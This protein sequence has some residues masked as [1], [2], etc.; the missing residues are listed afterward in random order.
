MQPTGQPTMQ[1]SMQPTGQPTML[2]TGQPTGQPTMQPSGQPTMQPTGQPTR[3]PTGQPSGKPTM[4]PR[5]Q[6]TGQPTR[7]PTGQPTV[8][9]TGKPSG[10]P[11][12]KPSGQPTRQPTMQPTGQP[13]MQ[14]TGQPTRQP[15]GQP[16]GQ[17]TV[18]PT[19][20]PSVRPSSHPSR[21]RSY[22]PSRNGDTLAP[23]QTQK[24]SLPLI[25][26][27]IPTK[28][29]P[30]PTSIPTRKTYPTSVPSSRPTSSI[31]PSVPKIKNIAVITGAH[32]VTLSVSLIA[33]RDSPGSIYCIALKFGSTP[34]SINDV[35]AKGTR[36]NYLSALTHTSTVIIGLLALT[37]Y[38]AFC[39]VQNAN[40][41]GITYSEMM[42]SKVS[43]TTS[44]CQMISFVSSP[45][46]VY[47]DVSA[48]TVSTSSSTYMF[49]YSLDS[50]PSQGSI[51]VTPMITL[52]NGTASSV[53][54][55]SIPSSSIFLS[56]ASTTT[57]KGSFYI[58][59]KSSVSGSF[60][61]QLAISG[62]NYK[63]Y[64]STSVAVSILSL[65]QPLPAP[66]LVSC[67]FS[68]S[69]GSIIVTFDSA[70]DLGGITAATWSCS[71]MFTFTGSNSAIW[72]VPSLIAACVSEK[73]LSK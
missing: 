2:P 59:T 28:Q 30:K 66:Q 55:I 70:T 6:P 63:N 1:P 64:V 47:G 5:S 68:D 53:I 13:T 65:N 21:R 29:T 14:P 54:I 4:F 31:T 33:P 60:Q 22:S 44:C 8:Q 43:F 61:V 27:H 37:S 48:Y 72:Y 16:S 57:L 34:V 46:S 67:F 20:H 39:Y 9:P 19:A 49:T 71:L 69:G 3:Q 73:F 12:R 11:S 38:D 15:T 36:T 7:R 52:S 45:V 50:P 42:N 17:P 35:M 56:S 26:T 51:T 10:K 58:S 25:P 24:P 18:W 40:G 32:N 62:V 41:A 23:S